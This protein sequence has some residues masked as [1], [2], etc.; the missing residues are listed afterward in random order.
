MFIQN[1]IHSMH[2]VVKYS[3]SVFPHH[4]SFQTFFLQRVFCC[5]QHSPRG[6]QKPQKISS[7]WCLNIIYRQGLSNII[8]L[9]FIEKPR[10]CELAQLSLS[11]WRWLTLAGSLVCIAKHHWIV[12]VFMRFFGLI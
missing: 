10:P 6:K 12:V 2:P 5:K 7:S 4:F 1:C 8:L 11:L 9:H 3:L